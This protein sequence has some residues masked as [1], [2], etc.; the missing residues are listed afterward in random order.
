MDAFENHIFNIIENST[1]YKFSNKQ[2]FNIIDKQY[3]ITFKIYYY[4]NL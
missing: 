2:T 1:K 3:D 4:I